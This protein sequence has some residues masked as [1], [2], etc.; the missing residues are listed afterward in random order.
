LKVPAAT[1]RDLD[2]TASHGVSKAEQQERQLPPRR[3][4]GVNTAWPRR[5]PLRSISPSINK[6]SFELKA[7]WAVR[8]L[9]VQ[10][11]ALPCPRH[12]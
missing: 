4:H 9:A 1:S 11:R 5:E 10:I 7:E 8:G 12:G 3:R 2:G 6:S